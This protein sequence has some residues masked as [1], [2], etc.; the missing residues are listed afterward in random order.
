MKKT[1]GYYIVFLLAF[2]SQGCFNQSFAASVDTVNIY[3][4]AMQKSIKCVVITPESYRNE[5]NRFPVVYLLHGYGGSYSNWIQRVPDIK[6]YA[7][8]FQMIIICPDGAKDSWYIDSP[9]D[10][11]SKYETYVAQEIPSFIDS[12]YRT[13][14]E[15]SSRAITG[16]SMGGHGGLLLAW[17]H[18]AFFGAAGSMSGAV[19]LVSL[20]S[21][22]GLM[23]VLGD[24]TSNEKFYKYSVLNVVK[25][26]INNLPVV[27][28]DCGINDPFIEANRTLN[29]ELLS[30]KIPHT[31]IEREGTHNWDYWR[32][33]IGY[34]LMFFHK[35]FR[36]NLKMPVMN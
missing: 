1:S 25:E 17:R 31:Y 27:V 16:L 34:Q 5:V 32:N 12:A 35:Y 33:A 14:A 6:N 8:E 20:A 13:I 22:Y 7:D 28:F 11:T 15:R 3:S 9:E 10:N 23:K 36:A 24:T 29:Q 30:L 18:D 2:L 19:D 4:K 21:K 26:K